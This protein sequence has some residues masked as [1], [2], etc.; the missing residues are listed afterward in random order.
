MSS[1]HPSGDPNMRRTRITLRQAALTL[2]LTGAIA[3]IAAVLFAGAPAPQADEYVVFAYNE[4]GMHCMQQDFSE[5]MILPPFNT[6][7]AQ[8]VHKRTGEDPDIISS[9][10][11][12]K[13]TLPANTHSADKCNF[14]SYSNGLLGV[15]LPT[16][17]GV[18][19][20]GL[21]G[22]MAAA[23]N[24]QFAATGIPLTPIDDTGRENP[25]PLALVSVERNGAPVGTTQTVVPVSWEMSCNL[26][27]NTPGVSTATDILRA[28]DRLH[29]TDLEHSKPV[30][31]AQ[32]HADPA[33]GA[34]GRPGI[35]TLSGAMHT[36]HA[37]RMAAAH[38][39]NECYAC[40]P[41]FRTNC[42]RD[43]HAL[44]GMNCNS[45]HT[46]MT[47]VGNPN[48]RPWIDE[49]RCASCHQRSGFEFEQANTLFRDSVG[50]KGI[51]CMSCHGS[52]HA[53][54]PATN[55][56]DNIQAIMK[57]GHAGT[58][59]TCIVCHSSTPTRPFPHER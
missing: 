18:A 23:A 45:C 50:H 40:H 38:L 31:C 48:R 54:T 2:G 51:A 44:A 42:Q 13:Y 30:F 57:Q 53:I 27:H 11:T 17:V 37:P 1:T 10:V 41:G 3:G 35:S 52:P 32:C 33:V 55:A 5:M 56:A 36:A 20:F 34:T 39:D 24:R 14:W 4:L 47:A 29:S 58:I 21:S 7:R 22:T 49:P 43:V 12:L 16:D 26:C 46:S 8:V 28:H 25:Y 15:E 9:G 6:L 19:G 59:D